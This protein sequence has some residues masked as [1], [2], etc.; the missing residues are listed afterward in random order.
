MDGGALARRLARRFEID[1]H[2]LR[3]LDSA[4]EPHPAGVLERLRFATAAGETAR[5]FL[6]RPQT[7]AGAA[8][9][10]AVMIIHAHGGAYGI[11][12]DELL[13]GR[14]AL[15]GPLGPALA[16]RGVP[17]F[18]IDLPCFG[19]RRA[20]SESARSKARLW[21]GGSL[22]GQMLGELASALGW[23]AA[24]DDVDAARIGVFGISMGATLGYWLAAV[25]DRV[26][27]LAQLCCFADFRALIDCGA[28]DRHGPYLTIPGLLSETTTGAIA[29]LVA[30]RPQLIGIG[31][32]DPLTPPQAA[33]PALAE[34]AAA[35]ARAGAADRLT[36][37]RDPEAGHEE[38]PAMRA[39][40]LDFLAGA[41][42]V[43]GH[44]SDQGERR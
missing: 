34:V 36:L 41:R 12:A 20:P 13:A 39:G 7:R 19:V 5:G 2:P 15:L 35:Y 6:L 21:M 9:G 33:E 38:T 10:P 30:P 31:D 1:E 11:G 44:R 27:R 3:F 16:A 14:P 22:A 43:A 23:L 25:D 4:A 32:R 8:P 24:R 42:R 40:V 17:A 37:L 29:G 28:H 18:C 26:A